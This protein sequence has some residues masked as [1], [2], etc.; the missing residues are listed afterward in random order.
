M[1]LAGVAVEQDGVGAADRAREEQRSGAVQEA[2]GVRGR[3]EGVVG[4]DDLALAAG[5]L[6]AGGERA[7]DGERAGGGGEREV[8]RDVGAMRASA[9]VT[10]SRTV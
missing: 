8:E 7:R 10:T 9:R 6:Y 1:P 2:V 5:E 4:E 3:A